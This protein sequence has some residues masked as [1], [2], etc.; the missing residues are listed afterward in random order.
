MAVAGHSGAKM[1]M[2]A[3]SAKCKDLLEEHW[4]DG[5][6]KNSKLGLFP[7]FYMSKFEKMSRGGKGSSNEKQTVEI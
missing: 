4:Y 5:V 2:K 7:N 1:L 6:G 3:L